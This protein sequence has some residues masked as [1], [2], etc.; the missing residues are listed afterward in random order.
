MIWAAWGAALGAFLA[1]FVALGV[2]ALQ[3]KDRRRIQASKVSG[4]VVSLEGPTERAILGG[5]SECDPGNI[6]PRGRVRFKVA[7]HSDEPISA[8]HARLVAASEYSIRRIHGNSIASD[9]LGTLVPQEQRLVE[10]DYPNVQLFRLFSG[11]PIPPTFYPGVEISFVDA[12]G[13]RWIRSGN[14]LL[15]PTASFYPLSM[16]VQNRWRQGLRKPEGYNPM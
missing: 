1:F 8:V 12:N 10:L 13:R 16:R 14:G 7:N 9:L 11:R 3:I 6:H 15:T 2:F 5:D 4:W